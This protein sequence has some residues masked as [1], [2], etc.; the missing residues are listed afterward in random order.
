[1]LYFSFFIFHFSFFIPAGK[2]QQLHE[3]SYIRTSETSQGALYE[4]ESGVHTSVKPFY[5]KEISALIP[6]DTAPYRSPGTSWASRKLFRE[7]FI[8]LRNNKYTL[9]AD[10]LLRLSGGQ[11]IIS[12]EALGDAALGVRVSSNLG[13]KISLYADVLYNQT[14][15]PRYVTQMIQSS[16]T[17]P[18]SACAFPSV[19]GGSNYLDYSGYASYGFMKHFT[20]E[21]GFGKNFWG[22]GY[23][24]LFLSDNA[25]NYPYFKITTKV[26]KIKYVNLFANFKDMRSTSLSRW[27]NFADK[28]GAFH[29]LS[30][31]IGKQLNID[32]FEAIIWQAGDSAGSRGFDINYLNP[33]I[34]YRPV[35]F[36]LGNPDNSNIGIAASY[37]L[38]KHYM[39]YGQLLID[40][41]MFSE[42]KNGFLNRLKHIIHPNDKTLKW[43]Y[44][45]NKQAWQLGFKAYDLFGVKHLFARVEYNAARPYTWS[46]RYVIMNYGH[47]NQPLAHP[48]GS[49]FSELCGTVSYNYKRWFIEAHA[50]TLAIGLDSSGMHAG[51][52]IFKPT[53]DTYY[54]DIKNI[55]VQQYGNE[56]G[57]GI[58]TKIN[59]ASLTLAYMVNPANNLRLEAG[60]Y[61]RTAQSSLQSQ[62]SGYA[63]IGISTTLPQRKF[64]Y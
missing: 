55:P 15:F 49:N 11:D 23:R 31:D 22:E 19:L 52:D 47:Y 30:W 62:R 48:A 38:G 14:S 3:Q 6:P 1:M 7:S 8:Q 50:V 44:W 32:L 2:S 28:Y 42:V 58:K 13:N 12:K 53:F 64:D 26:W 17:V 43:G 57:Q 10:P 59:F 45:T 20:L 5:I 51:A 18:G 27:S 16:R 29:Y 37:R 9:T 46:H 61:Y 35:E 24:S 41:L 54:T 36:S 63:W 40:D 4:S 25:Y 60:F 33:F 39:F 21:A 56:I 34:F